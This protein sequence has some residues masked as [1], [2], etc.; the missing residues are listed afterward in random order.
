MMTTLRFKVP[1]PD[2]PGYLKRMRRAL[3]FQR[4]LTDDL[5]PE[6]LDELVKFLAGYVTEPEGEQERI[7]ALYDASQ[8]EFEQLLGALTGENAPDPTG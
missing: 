2:S 3:T 4:S 6:K 8:E 5:T 1:G 7:E